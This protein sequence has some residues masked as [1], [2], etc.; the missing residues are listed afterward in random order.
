MKWETD[1]LWPA[2]NVTGTRAP[3]REIKPLTAIRGIAALGIVLYHAQF[4]LHP[5]SGSTATF[6]PGSPKGYLFVDLFFLLSGF[7]M[8]HVHGDDFRGSWRRPYARFLALRIVR[9]YPLYLL[10]LALFLAVE[11][12]KLGAATSHPAFSYNTLPSFWQS[13]LML[14]SW[15]LDTAVRWNV[16]AWSI[17]AECAAYLLTPALFSAVLYA[18]GRA[19]WPFIAACGML[20]WLLATPHRG[21]DL[22]YDFG[23][24]RCIAEYSLG[25]ALFRIYRAVDRNDAILRRQL[26]WALPVALALSLANVVA[27]GNDLLTVALFACDILGLAIASGRTARLFSSPPA[28]F[29]GRISY[30]LY[31]V[32]YLLIQVSGMFMGRYFPTSEMAAINFAFAAGAVVLSLIAATILFAQV[33]KPARQIGRRL[34]VPATAWPRS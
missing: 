32:H 7:I 21:L 1:R 26:A 4:L 8:S 19:V 27:A 10:V 12:A 17:S 6:A 31:M 15:H 28:M 34:M 22:T 5:L 33:E 11:T 20:L 24:V 13:L 2:N 29:L 18:S 23:A 16:P 30:S 14:Q 25:I 9:I 3:A